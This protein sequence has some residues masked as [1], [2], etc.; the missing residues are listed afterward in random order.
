MHRTSN[1]AAAG[2]HVWRSGLQSYTWD[3]R[4]RL[5]QAVTPTASE[6]YICDGLS[7]RSSTALLVGSTQTVTAT[8]F[9]GLN[10]LEQ[11]TS[12]GSTDTQTLRGEAPPPSNACDELNPGKRVGHRHS[13]RPTPASSG[14]CR[15]P[16][17]TGSSSQG[18][19]VSLRPHRRHVMPGSVLRR[20]WA[21]PGSS[22]C[23]SPS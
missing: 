19:A 1:F 22:S 8:L 16:V 5:T 3:T 18:L 7:R 11:I 6:S 2:H 4:N 21:P 12:G 14:Y 20:R 13:P 10:E 9:D 23:G 17:R 15:S